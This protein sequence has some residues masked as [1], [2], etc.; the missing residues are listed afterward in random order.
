MT[1]EENQRWQE[2]RFYYM[3]LHIYQLRHDMMDVI[4][5]IETI[6]QMGTIQ[7]Q[8]VKAL[9]GILISDIANT[10]HKEELLYLASQ[11]K[12]NP[13]DIKRVFGFTYR[14]MHYQAGLEE[15]NLF[16]PRLHPEDNQILQDFMKIVDKFKGGII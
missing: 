4:Y 6:S 3:C 5:A 7:T 15:Q 14:Q 8:R 9:A 13:K 12:I 10:P 2:I 1:K 16:K 11:A